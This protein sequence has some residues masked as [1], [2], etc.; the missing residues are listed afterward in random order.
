M[1]EYYVLVP[2]SLNLDRR[3]SIFPP[4]FNFNKEYCY[5]FISQLVINLQYQKTS[6]KDL[7]TVVKKFVSMCSTIN[8][9]IFRDYNKYLEYLYKDFTGEGRLLWRNNY[10]KGKCYSYRLPD[11]YWGNGELELIP[12]FNQ[13]L[14]KN[15]KKH[16]IPKVQRS[17][18]QNYNFVI[19]YFDTKRFQL[20]EESALNELYLQYQQTRDYQKYLSNAVKVMNFKNGY[21]SFI[22]HPETDGRLHTAITQ[23]PKICRKYLKYDN[24]KL[25]EVDLSSSIP[26]FLS[27]LLSNNLT[28]TNLTSVINSKDII[29]HYMLVESSAKPTGKEIQRFKDL[30]LKNEL[31][32]Y[33]SDD[34]VNLPNFEI[35]FKN[36]FN[37]P[38]DGDTDDLRKYSK[39]RFLS[40]LFAKPTDYKNEQTV[41]KKYFPTINELIIKFKRKKFRDFKKSEWHKKLSYLVFQLESHFMLNIIAREI[42][43]KYK[44]KIPLFTLHDCIVVKESHLEIV[45]NQMKEIFVRE[46]GYAPNLTKK[47]WE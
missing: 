34:F 29:S 37:I 13:S 38:F 2:K 27:Y 15:I 40:M 14:L 18:K 33:F 5:Y 1:N 10:K 11:Y 23:F 44:R 26:F 32:S 19:G 6:E 9:N 25:A 30:V 47:I 35:S 46:I 41:F 21:F 16:H 7:K 39:K 12:I 45:Y 8:Q 24:E 22:H 42:N 36:E 4:D 3:L 17:V 20:D 43:N 31:Y 28:P